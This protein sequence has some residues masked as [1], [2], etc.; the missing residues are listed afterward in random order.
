M[1][2]N[3]H[4]IMGP[5]VREARDVAPHSQSETRGHFTLLAVSFNH[6]TVSS[7]EMGVESLSSPSRPAIGCKGKVFRD[8]SITVLAESPSHS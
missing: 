6:T 3:L 4:R 2:T 8:G 7:A 1:V 5:S